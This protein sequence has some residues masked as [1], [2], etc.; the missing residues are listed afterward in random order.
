MLLTPQQDPRNG[1]TSKVGN[2]LLVQGGG[3]GGGV[4]QSDHKLGSRVRWSG[5]LEAA[6][7]SSQG[8]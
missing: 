2:D 3:G 6:F 1:Q 4:L 5:D 8:L 7:G